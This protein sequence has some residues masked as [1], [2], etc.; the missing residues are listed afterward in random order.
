[1]TSTGEDVEKREPLCTVGENVKLVQLLRKTVWRVLKKLKIVLPY[2]P[3]IPLLSRYLK[4]VK[5][6]S[7]RQI[8]TPT[9]TATSFTVAKIWKQAFING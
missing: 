4:K 2:D 9:F 3:A 6:P 7:Q 1:M 8:C 5:S